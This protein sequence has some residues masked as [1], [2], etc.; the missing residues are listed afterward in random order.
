M[1]PL[2]FSCLRRLGAPLVCLV[3]LAA[4]G[5]QKNADVRPGALPPAT[6]VGRNTIG[7]LINDQVWKVDAGDA[8]L[9]SSPVKAWYTPGL[10]LDV[11]ATH[12]GGVYGDSQ[13]RLHLDGLNLHPGTYDL[14]QGTRLKFEDYESEFGDEYAA[15]GTIGGGAVTLTKVQAVAATGNSPAYTIVAGTFSFTAVSPYTGAVVHL[16]NGLFDVKAY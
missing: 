1:K 16:T 7:C 13:L 3:L 14:D 5:C 9:A 4:A 6:E 12:A 15:G 10:S 2:R 11:E 8:S